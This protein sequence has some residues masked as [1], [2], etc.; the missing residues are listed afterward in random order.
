MVQIVNVYLGVVD[1]NGY[2]KPRFS[3]LNVPNDKLFFSLVATVGHEFC[4]VFFTQSA[5]NLSISSYTRN[6]E[7]NT[8]HSSPMFLESV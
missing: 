7:V 1:I 3:S 8:R 6:S 5:M 4:S 2:G